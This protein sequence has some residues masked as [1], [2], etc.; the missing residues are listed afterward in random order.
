MLIIRVWLEDHPTAPMRAVITQQSDV[1]DDG[2]PVRLT[3]SSAYDVCRIVRT[4]L[5][6]LVSGREVRL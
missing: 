1:E 6:E 3:A 2:P 5:N 4:W